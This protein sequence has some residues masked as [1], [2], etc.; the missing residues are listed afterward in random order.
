MKRLFILVLH[1][2]LN[3][4]I[5]IQQGSPSPCIILHYNMFARNHA[6]S[7]LQLTK[8]IFINRKNSLSNSNSSCDFWHLAIISPII[9]LL[10]LSLP[11]FNQMVPQLS[12]FSLKLNFSLKPLLPT[13]PWMILGIFLLLLHPLPT[14]SL[15]LK[16]FIVT[17]FML[18]LAVILGRLTV[19]M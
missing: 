5:K 14:S 8:N 1:F 11:Y 13:L 7:I 6:K 10:H 16:F 3:Q 15:T 4:L 9:L 2:R 18:F 17:F 12:V 19:W